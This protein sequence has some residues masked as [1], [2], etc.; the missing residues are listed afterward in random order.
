MEKG[1]DDEEIAPPESKE[2]TV[3]IDG[4][5]Y[6]RSKNPYWLS[7]PEAPEY[8]YVEKGR[9]F[10]GMQHYL[11]DALAKAVGKEKDKAQ[12]KAIPPDKLQELVKAEVDR[13]LAGAGS[14]RLRLPGYGGKG[15]LCGPFGGRDP[16]SG[17][18]PEL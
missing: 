11:I 14:G 7:Y 6:V 9:E 13:I 3:M 1:D 5:P 4:K 8:I 18:S 15:A 10:I 2:E 12:G 16:R 17:H